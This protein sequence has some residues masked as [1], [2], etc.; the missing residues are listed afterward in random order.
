M[1]SQNSWPNQAVFENVL[2][3]VP[4]VLVGILVL[5]YIY[6]RLFSALAGIPGPA[7]ACVSRLWMAYH[8]YQGDMHIV[9]PKLHAKY[10]TLVRMA[11][12][13]LSVADLDAIREIYGKS[14]SLPRTSTGGL[15][16]FPFSRPRFEIL[17]E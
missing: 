12:D 17:Q 3:T 14:L 1:I 13:E 16:S 11:P 2:V 6:I 7:Q 9:L 5:Y 8:S 15:P 4:L 10:G